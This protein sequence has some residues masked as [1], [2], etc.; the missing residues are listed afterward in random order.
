MKDFFKLIKA[1]QAIGEW[2][3]FF[4]AYKEYVSGGIVIRL[5]RICTG[6]RDYIL[7]LV[8]ILIERSLPKLNN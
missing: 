3:I 4:K 5:K 1:S 7:L 8:S 2:R 6:P